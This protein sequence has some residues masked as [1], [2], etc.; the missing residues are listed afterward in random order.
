MKS[1][2][3]G[4]PLEPILMWPDVL[5]VIRG[6]NHNTSP[7]RSQGQNYKP[8]Y[9]L[10]ELSGRG[11]R[12][13]VW[14]LLS[15]VWNDE[16]IPVAWE[17]NIIVSLFK[18]KDPEMP[19]NYRPITL[20]S[21]LQKILTG[22]ITKFTYKHMAIS[23][24]FD[25]NQGGYTTFVVFIDLVKAYDKVLLELALE[26]RMVILMNFGKV[27]AKVTPLTRSEH[28]TE[29]L[30]PALMAHYMD[31]CMLMIYLKAFLEEFEDWCKYWWMEMLL[32]KERLKGQTM[33]GSVRGA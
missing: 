15:K 1:N 24:L 28:L 10:E 32:P 22:V 9:Y 6:M 27:F 14:N 8:T 26:V 2:N 19:T 31:Y 4:V 3:E 5:E 16:E 23:D 21:I 17:E 13:A 18:G 33:N 25:E 20:I 11:P 7:G 30:H 12:K 29:T